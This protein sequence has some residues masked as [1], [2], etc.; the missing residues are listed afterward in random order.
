LTG[1]LKKIGDQ[2]QT[3]GWIGD[4]QVFQGM[5]ETQ[6]YAFF[7]VRVAVPVGTTLTWKN[8][9]V[10]VHTATDQKGGWD[11]G[12][13]KPGEAASITFDKPGTFVYVC[14]PHPWMIGEITVQ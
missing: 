9:G 2:L 5:V 10:T 12:D 11:T 14:Q 1:P 13:V 8:T 3:P 7:P 4:D 6:D